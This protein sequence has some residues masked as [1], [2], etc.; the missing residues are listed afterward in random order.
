MTLKKGKKY[1]AAWK[2]DHQEAARIYQSGL[3]TTQT[4]AIFNVSA[5]SILR[6]LK[7]EGVQLRSIS[8][9]KVIRH[10]GAKSKQTGGY[11][12][13]RI[14]K[15]R[16]KLEHVLIAEK[17]LGRALQK[18]EH[19]HHI[20]CDPADNRNENLLICSCAYHIALHHA[21]NR[22]DYWRNL[23]NGDSHE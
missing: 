15:G 1:P 20:N 19:V 16:R 22:H 17:A 14:G 11:V 4:A 6:A 13:V 3:S 8:E 10:A 9:A 23:K 7:Q 18:G 21:M 2:F 12:F 5:P